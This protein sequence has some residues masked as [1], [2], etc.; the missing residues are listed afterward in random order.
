M[1]S[2]QAIVF[3]EERPPRDRPVSL[4]EAFATASSERGRPLALREIEQL[5]IV[6]LLEQTRGNRTAA[7][8]ILGISYP[9][10][11]KKILDYGIDFREIAARRMRPG[12]D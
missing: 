5:Y 6:W 11:Q 4:A 10:M 9:T 3:A 2:A 12:N 1:I 8:R 7:S